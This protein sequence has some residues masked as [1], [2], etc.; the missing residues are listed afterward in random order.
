MLMGQFEFLEESTYC[1]ACPCC[2]CCHGHHV[3]LPVDFA[4]EM[5]AA[6]MTGQSKTATKL[7]ETSLVVTKTDQSE[8]SSTASAGCWHCV[9]VLL[10]HK[11][12]HRHHA[13]HLLDPMLHCW[14]YPCTSFHPEHGLHRLICAL[15]GHGLPRHAH[16]VMDMALAAVASLTTI[17]TTTSTSA[18]HSWRR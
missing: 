18:C 5:I 11:Y 1:F 16:H 7:G 17:D 9:H 14:H 12:G 10:D 2:R 6:M 3:E 13:Y 4:L 15:S 8:G